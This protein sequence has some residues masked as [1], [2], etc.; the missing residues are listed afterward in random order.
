[1]QHVLV[2]YPGQESFVGLWRPHHTTPWVT[3]PITN[4][5]GEGNRVLQVLDA[6]L[7][8]EKIGVAQLTHIGAFAG[9]ATYT[10]L[11]LCLA[12]ANMLAWSLDLPLFELEA[13]DTL[14]QSLPVA[15]ERA[16]RGKPIEARYP[17][18]LG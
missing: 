4:V 1:M 14:P 2:F 5:K 15:L 8:Q 3:L 6:L 17:Q 18:V 9:P 11:R 13:A 10:Q 12:T 16:R 7:E